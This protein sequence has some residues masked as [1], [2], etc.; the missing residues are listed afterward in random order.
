MMRSLALMT[1]YVVTFLTGA[2]GLIYE[3]TWQK[4]LSRLLGSDNTATAIILAIFLGGLSLGYYLCGKLTTKAGDYFKW[5]AILEG[6][7]GLW[8]LFFPHIF[9]VVMFATQSWSFSPPLAIII[10]GVFCA[11]LLIG[12]PTICMGGTVPFLTRGISR[13]VEE[14]TSVHARVYAV[15]T[16]GAFAGALLAGFYLIPAFGLP[17][18]IKSSSFINLGAFGFFF[19]LSRWIGQPVEP[20][21]SDAMHGKVSAGNGSRQYSH[22]SPLPLLLI[23][24]LSGFYVMTLENVLIRITGLSAG[25]SSYTFSIIISVFVLAIAVGSWLVSRL[26]YISPKLLFYNQLFI[27]LFLACLYLSLDSWPYAAHIIR[28]LFQSNSLGFWAYYVNLFLVL[29]AILLLPLGLIGA[30]IPI[31]FHMLKQNI[32]NVGRDSGLL[33]SFNTIGSLAGSLISGIVLYYIFNNPGIYLTA[34]MLAAIT[35]C[36]AAWRLPGKYLVVSCFQIIC[37]GLL[38]FYLPGYD[39]NRFAKGTFIVRDPLFFTCEGPEGFFENYTKNDEVVFYKDGPT[40]TVSVV[41]TK[42]P[43]ESNR[44]ADNLAIFINGKCD[45][46]T[47]RDIYTIRLAA[48]IPALLARSSRDVMI[49][50]MG[51]GVTAGELSLYP[52]VRSIDVSEISPLVAD[53][54]PF[55]AQHTHSVHKDPRMHIHIGDAL[56]VIGRSNKK[57]DIIISEP[58]NPWVIGVDQLYTEEFYLLIKEHLTKGGALLQWIHTYDADMKMLG[59]VMNTLHHY[60]KECHCFVGNW[61]DFLLL[62]TDTHISAEDMARA[63]K[64]LGSHEHIKISLEEI[65]IASLD[66]ILMR[67]LQSPAMIDSR[68]ERFGVQS[69][70]FPQ[71]HY[72]AGK[73]FFCG[74]RVDARVLLDS[75][76]ACC[77][78]DFL[79]GRKYGKKW[80]EGSIGKESFECL[81]QSLLG[82]MPRESSLQTK[83]ISSLKLKEYLYDPL[84]HP[85]DNQ[86]KE[87]FNVDL[88]PLIVHIDHSSQDWE[89]AGLGDASRRERIDALMNHVRKFR[90][91]IVPYPIEGLKSLLDEGIT[92]ETDK[93]EKNA[94]VLLRTILMMDE[95][96]DLS[97]IRKVM[98]KVIQEKDGAIMVKQEDRWMLNIV[99]KKLGD[100]LNPFY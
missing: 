89:S 56:R 48:H 90:N 68:Y 22:V 42:P 78:Q 60:F 73:N 27:T 43:V 3:V 34:T 88:L 87:E 54:L 4:Y 49:I 70:D 51:T 82:I 62:A 81:F 76:T 65:G 9:S 58:S 8:C 69:M 23:A 100:R 24:F 67:Q 93:L 64:L 14:S 96:A 25:S 84:A 63:E 1:T 57:W 99:A 59:M 38:F 17:L 97:A 46:S 45:S 71:L 44:T 31:A 16:A 7:I 33:L 36:I 80:A 21:Q 13:N 10:Q 2:S 5:Y 98:V 29:A 39:V 15:N 35:T 85:M 19:I 77:Y 53:A 83:M 40:A 20:D 12:I 92:Y 74:S 61:S 28:I 50:G 75:E 66:A 72:L 26:K 55:F 32:H 18:T 86:E 52:A 79:L 91:W 95:K 37:L 6:I 47:Y 41:K 30:T 11:F 94:I